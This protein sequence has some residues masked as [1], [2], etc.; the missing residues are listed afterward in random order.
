MRLGCSY[1]RYCEANTRQPLSSIS[2]KPVYIQGVKWER[3]DKKL[4]LQ[5]PQPPA[6][7]LRRIIPTGE[8][9]GSFP[10]GIG[11]IEFRVRPCGRLGSK[12]GPKP[13]A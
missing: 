6:Q 13:V 4:M 3:P 12:C 1:K 8:L 9:P 2:L 11:R 5:A 7:H 10:H